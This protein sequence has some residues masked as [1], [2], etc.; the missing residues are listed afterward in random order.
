[1]DDPRYESVDEIIDQMIGNE[2]CNNYVRIN[3]RKEAIKYALDTAD[4][5]DLVLI[6][7][8]GRDNYMAIED[9]REKYCDYN[10]IKDYFKKK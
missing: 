2:K 6:L 1:M 9:R 8:K 3:D 4:T 10:V 5:S 7:G